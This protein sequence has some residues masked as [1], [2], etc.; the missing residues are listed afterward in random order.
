[1]EMREVEQ[2]ED[3]LAANQAQVAWCEA[4]SRGC[5][6]QQARCLVSVL[7]MHWQRH[8]QI[9]QRQ[10]SKRGATIESTNCWWSVS[11]VCSSLWPVY[12]VLL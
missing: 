12:K 5:S 6:L 10:K 1:M 9:R 11:G 7:G 2:G 3:E 4:S 8:G